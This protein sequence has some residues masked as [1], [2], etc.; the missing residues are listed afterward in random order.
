M[1][2]F[3]VDDRFPDH[4]KLEALEH[5]PRLWADSLALWL[6]AGCRSAGNL[7]DG[8][9][10]ASRLGRMTPLGG[11]AVKIADQLV[12]IGLWEK[13]EKGYKFHDWFDWQPSAEEVEYQR[14]RLAEKQKRYRDR[15][16]GGN[17]PGSVTGNAPVADDPGVTLPRPDPSRPYEKREMRAREESSAT[18]VANHLRTRAWELPVMAED[19]IRPHSAATPEQVEYSANFAE[20]QC[21]N[22]GGTF[23]YFLKVLRDVVAGTHK[24]GNGKTQPEPGWIEGS[25]KFLEGLEG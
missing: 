14:G 8:N 10:S 24:T 11:R 2:W 22:S 15:K 18:A 3:K 23:A 9:V 7:T 5:D 19:L 16:R 4:E 6:V 17:E 25:R 12:E 21:G 20:A 1:T 13:T